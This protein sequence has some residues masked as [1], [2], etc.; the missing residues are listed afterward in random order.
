MTLAEI[1]DSLIELVR[2]TI[3]WLAVCASGSSTTISEQGEIL[4]R[5]PAVLTV[6]DE[7][8]IAP[9]SVRA[10][11]N[12]YAPR[13]ALLAGASNLRSSAAEKKGDPVTGYGVYPILDALR[14]LAG[15]VLE[16][17]SGGKG[18]LVV[19]GERLV[20]F[21]HEG[22]WYEVSAKVETDFQNEAQQWPR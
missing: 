7:S 2:A 6:L 8:A 19:E 10:L 21:T 1:E 20:A 9:R 14:S 16:F 18:L 3:P 15:T 12:S 5:L 22:T 17:D 13:W 11:S 4:V